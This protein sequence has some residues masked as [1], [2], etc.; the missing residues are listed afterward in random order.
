MKSQNLH[1][2]YLISIKKNLIS[3]HIL[4]SEI[5]DEFKELNSYEIV[6]KMKAHYPGLKVGRFPRK[7]LNLDFERDILPAEKKLTEEYGF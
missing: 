5:N 1:K 6:K 7:A 4:Q 2:M 3:N